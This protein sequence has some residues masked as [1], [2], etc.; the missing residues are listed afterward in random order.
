MLRITWM[1]MFDFDN[2]FT[3]FNEPRNRRPF[4]RIAQGYARV[5]EITW[6]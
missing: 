4:G 2:F 5:C 6:P 1:T 3:D